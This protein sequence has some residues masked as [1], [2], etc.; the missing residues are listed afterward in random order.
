MLAVRTAAMA[1]SEKPGY[2]APLARLLP[3]VQ[4]VVSDELGLR[5]SLGGAQ[6]GGDGGLFRIPGTAKIPSSQFDIALYKYQLYLHI[7]CC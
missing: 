1:A 3:A 2:M 6:D 5:S 4:C 7:W